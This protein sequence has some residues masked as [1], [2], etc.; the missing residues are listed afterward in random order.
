MFWT[1]YW[2]ATFILKDRFLRVPQG[3]ISDPTVYRWWVPLTY[4]NPTS[5]SMNIIWMSDNESSMS[6]Q[7]LEASNDQWVLFNI[8][9][10]G[11]KHWIRSS[12]SLS[13]GLFT[14]KNP[15]TPPKKIRKI[16]KKSQKSK[17]FFWGF[18]IRTP[19]LGVNKPSIS[20]FKFFLFIKFSYTQK[21]PKK[22]KKIRKKSKKIRK[23]LKKSEKI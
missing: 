4:K 20:V 7:D 11:K 21:N 22:S 2:L 17:D 13:E 15:R 8:E 19:Y 12:T 9:Q 1:R 16:Q 6:V 3:N 5:Q 14:Q 23:N 18:K 10:A